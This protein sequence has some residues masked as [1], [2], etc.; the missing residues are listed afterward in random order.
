MIIFI[1]TTHTTKTATKTTTTTL[2]A[3]TPTTTTNH[4]RLHTRGYIRQG[5]LGGTYKGEV[6]LLLCVLLSRED[7][8]VYA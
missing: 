5:E 2:T 6:F 7:C 8:P 3:T 1:Q 4:N